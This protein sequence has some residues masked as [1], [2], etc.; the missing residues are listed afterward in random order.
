MIIYENINIISLTKIIVQ[1]NL[2]A[3]VYA[4]T[5]PTSRK[6]KLNFKV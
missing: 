4:S 2:R 6:Q 1:E 3:L 5:A